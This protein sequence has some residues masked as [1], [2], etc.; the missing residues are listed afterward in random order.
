MSPL[1]ALF[2]HP[3]EMSVLPGLYPGSSS[4]PM[5]LPC[6]TSSCSDSVL[7]NSP[8]KYG[9]SRPGIFWI[10]DADFHGSVL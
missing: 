10:P 9:E 1:Q 2:P 8:Y 7:A 3:L 4:H 6:L 5:L